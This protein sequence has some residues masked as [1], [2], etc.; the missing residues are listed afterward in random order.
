MIFWEQL[1]NKKCVLIFSTIFSET[2]LILRRIQRDIVI[3]VYWYSSIVKGK[4]IPLQAWTGPKGSK[5]VRFPDFKT[6]V[7]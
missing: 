2:F 3:K 6:I 5:R 1:W 7:T 4:A